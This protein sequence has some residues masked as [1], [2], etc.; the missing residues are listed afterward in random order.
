MRCILLNKNTPI[1]LIEYN[2][3]HNAIVDIYDVY[4]IKYAPLSIQNANKDKSKSLVKELN[5]WL[6]NRGIPSWRKDIEHLLEKLNVSS[7]EELINKSFALSLSDQY[8]MKEENDTITWNDINFFT[9]DFQYKAYLKASFSSD[10]SENEKI[11]LH[12]PNNTTD[13]MIQ[14]AWIIEDG[15][16][17]LIKGSYTHSRQEPINEWLGSNI[18]RRLGFDH[19]NYDIDVIDNKLVSKCEN[20]VKENQEIIT[21]N[22]VFFT[23]KQNNHTSDMEHYIKIL[24]R[25]GIK[26]ARK[27]VENMFILDFLIMNYDR[28]MKNYGIIRDVDTLK[29][30]KVAPIF[31]NGQAMQCD[32]LINEMNFEDGK[33]KFFKNTDKKFSNYLQGFKTL[34]SI[35]I[36]KLDGLTNEYR[37]MLYKY[38]EYTEISNER[39]DK[40]VEGLKTRIDYLNKY[41]NK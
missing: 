28:H 1:A 25:Y 12:S 4:D 19:C 33:G 35:N 14:K 15:K 24:K 34:Q 36:T 26:D 37:E 5:N 31:D 30:I 23:R 18:S 32:K 21:A 29:W 3:D 8:W 17:V 11:D 27:N 39:I 22:D 38:Q 2:T 40:L 6:K 7:P 20:F 9:N 16:R 41:I 13:G 10:D